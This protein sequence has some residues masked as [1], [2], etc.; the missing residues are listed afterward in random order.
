MILH[1]IDR[2]VTTIP[3]HFRAAKIAKVV[4]VG[5]IAKLAMLHVNIDVVKITFIQ[6]IKLCS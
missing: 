2:D 5:V 4:H 1:D 6:C 3:N